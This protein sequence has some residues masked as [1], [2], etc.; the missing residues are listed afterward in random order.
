MLGGAVGVGVAYPLDTLKTKLQ[1]RESS[2]EEGNTN[3]FKLATGIVEDE[4]ISGFYGGVSST[5]AGQAVIKGVVFFVYEWAKALLAAPS[6]LTDAGSMPTGPFALLLAACISGAAGSL[7]VTPVERVKCVMQA[8]EAGTFET[9]LACVQQLLES[10]GAI[11][12][13]TRGLGATLLREVPAYAFYFVSYDATRD[14]LVDAALVPEA[15]V[16]LI[17][18]AVAGA[19]AWIPVYPI[20]VVKTN[21]QVAV[22]VDG[23]EARRGAAGAAGGSGPPTFIGTAQQ[24]W[25]TG[26]PGAFWDGITPKLARAVVNHAVTFYVFDLVC[27]LPVWT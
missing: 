7:V 9:P 25:E 15:I 16:P 10:D 2:S 20:D 1:A 4:G 13:L 27:A 3:F 8:S 26:G 23:G 12:L 18:G 5:M 14:F 21:I 24:I 6:P 17:G 11:G 19:M 22:K